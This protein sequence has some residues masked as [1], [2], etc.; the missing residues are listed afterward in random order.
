MPKEKPTPNILLTME[1]D[2][3][4][5]MKERYRREL[6]E[7]L[8]RQADSLRA[9]P[10]REARLIPLVLKSLFG[11]VR[12]KVAAGYERKTGLW[13]VPA[14]EAWGLKENQRLTPA[15]QFRACCT[16]AETGA[17]ER[18]SRL[19]GHL[20]FTLSDDA[21]R[22]CAESTG[23]QAAAH[24]LFERCP[25]AAGAQDVLILMMDGWLMRHRGKNWGVDA[26]EAADEHVHWHEIKSAILY[27]L[28]DITKVQ[29][30]RR[31]LIHKHIVAT[32]AGTEP[33]DFSQIVWREAMRMGVGNASRVY[34]VLDGGL[35]L[36]NIFED[37]F[38]RCA[39]GTLDFYHASEHLHVL[40]DN[41]FADKAQASRWCASL[42]HT[43]RHRS[44]K[45]LFKTLEELVLNPPEDT[46]DVIAAIQDA[47][48]YFERHREHM[49]YAKHAEEGLPIG[50]GSVESLCSQ[51][52][53]R[54]KRTGQ[55]WSGKGSAGLLELFVRYQNDELAAL[56]AA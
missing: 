46:P 15:L 55:F 1:E 6:E 50:S 11:D 8:Q 36:W 40:A 54:F 7:R 49:D 39:T 17:Y 29:P 26:E 4:S 16:A 30:T 31:A 44:S 43:L 37:R 9:C 18:A 38:S 24:P 52:Q 10:L 21:I 2:L 27:R 25:N 32:P 22:S 3:F 20:G 14:R 53:T 41:L 51:F 19:M 47:N 13:T 23:R 48:A 56:W 33:L 45:K 12:L 5:Q 35:W 42:L 34:L 28:S